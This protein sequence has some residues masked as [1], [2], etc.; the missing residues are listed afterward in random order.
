MPQRLWWCRGERTCIQGVKHACLHNIE[1]A[2][3]W[4]EPGLVERKEDVN[5]L[6]VLGLLPCRLRSP[7]STYLLVRLIAHNRDQEI[8]ALARG[9][10]TCVLALRL[11]LGGVVG[12]HNRDCSQPLVNS[13]SLLRSLCARCGGDPG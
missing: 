3:A 9:A 8:V 1:G 4:F 2:C 5:V 12:R 6:L 7:L 10:R 11:D 13:S